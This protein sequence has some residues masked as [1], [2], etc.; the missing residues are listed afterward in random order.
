MANERG[1]R[2]HEFKASRKYHMIKFFERRKIE[3]LLDKESDHLKKIQLERDLNYV[4]H[5]PK[6]RKYIAL[7]PKAPH[8]DEMMQTVNEIKDEIA[9]AMSTSGNAKDSVMKNDG[10]EVSE[11]EKKD[12][13]KDDF[14]I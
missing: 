11:K 6:D 10:E 1:R 7:F 8:S 5:F 2:K 9:T 12:M 13:E 3:R 4:L 14:F